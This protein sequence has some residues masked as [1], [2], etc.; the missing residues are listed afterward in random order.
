ML[1]AKITQL[2]RDQATL[3]PEFREKWRALTLSTQ[4]VDPQ[5]ATEAVEQA[6][7]SIGLPKPETV[8]F[9]SPYAALQ[10]R[11]DAV[12]VKQSQEIKD[13][14][15]RQL[16]RRLASQLEVRL[17]AQLSS[18]LEQRLWRQL[19]L[20][21]WN[22]LD[23]SFAQGIQ[24]EALA[25]WGVKL[26]FCI[27]VLKCSHNPHLWDIYQGLMQHCGWLIPMGRLCGIC[28]RPRQLLFNRENRLHAEAR[29]A[30]EFS[31]GHCLYA[32]QGVKIPQ[33][34]G[35]VFS[36]QWRVEW[37][38]TEDDPKL[39]KLLIQG[40]GYAR[41]CQEL[42]VKILDSCQEYTLLQVDEPRLHGEPI[43][44]LK[45]VC[46][47][48]NSLHAIRIPAW[49]CSVDEAICWMNWGINPM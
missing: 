16:W 15:R 24:P 39:R 38:F 37:L 8:F 13:R 22:R 36:H 1:H 35:E 5:K 45:R 18:E 34:Y 11:G 32:Y 31:D 6:Y 12:D 10:S 30:V 26:D 40:I 41:I 19:K 25:Y 9:T 48:T 49:I 4:P 17:F 46:P 2:T 7:R 29:P 27:S 47:I 21:L 43:Y 33:K 20:Q 44:L 42:P 3:I 14:L 23:D 28:D